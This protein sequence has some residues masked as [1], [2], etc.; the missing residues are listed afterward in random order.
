M[1]LQNINKDL[2]HHFLCYFCSK[3]VSETL[4]FNSY[5]NDFSSSNIMASL[6]TKRFSVLPSLTKYFLQ[7]S[8]SKSLSSTSFLLQQAKVQHPAPEFK[9]QAVVDG[10]FKEVSLSDFKGKWLVLFF[11]PLD[12]T[13][14][15]NPT[16]L[17]YHSYYVM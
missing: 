4:K 1:T 5:F 13:F 10:Q 16:L 7:K 12:F 17:I 2:R 8:S 6:I 11:Y 14:V 3:R 9:G 15:R